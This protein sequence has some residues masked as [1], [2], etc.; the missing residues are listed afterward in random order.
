MYYAKCLIT[1]LLSFV[2]SSLAFIGMR[3]FLIENLEDSKVF[4]LQ[5]LNCYVASMTNLFFCYSDK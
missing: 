3:V 5:V 4:L 2:A 1:S